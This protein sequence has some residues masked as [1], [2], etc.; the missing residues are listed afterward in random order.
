MPA[1]AVD[2]G[3]G[4]ARGRGVADALAAS[5]PRRCCCSRRSAAASAHAS[6]LSIH[7]APACLPHGKPN[8]SKESVDQRIPYGYVDMQGTGNTGDMR[9]HEGGDMKFTS[10]EP[11]VRTNTTMNLQLRSAVAHLAHTG[12][13]HHLPQHAAPT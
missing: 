1:A 11:L 7:A 4:G 6:S 10:W 3:G 9:R 2:V 8:V 13:Q 12:T 5:R